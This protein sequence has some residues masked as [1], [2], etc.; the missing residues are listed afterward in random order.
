MA[1][2]FKSIDYKNYI[3]EHCVRISFAN[4]NEDIWNMF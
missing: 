3:S 2:K 1:R 4:I